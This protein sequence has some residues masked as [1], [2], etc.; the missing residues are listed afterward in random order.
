MTDR[1]D[2]EKL[3]AL[4][5]ARREDGLGYAKLARFARERDIHERVAWNLEHAAR[6]SYAPETL[7]A[8]ERAYGL[9]PG[10]VSRFL[11]GGELVEIPEAGLLD[12]FSADDQAMI[13]EWVEALRRL[14]AE[15]RKS[16]PG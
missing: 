5:R 10:S 14:R 8:A 12:G 6:Q 13:R 2:W 16:Q 9:V 4:L 1:A 15:Q 11:A 7:R 3:G